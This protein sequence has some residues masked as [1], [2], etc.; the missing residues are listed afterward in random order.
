MR[1]H[2]V[3]LRKVGGVI[4]GEIQLHLFA[5]DFHLSLGKGSFE[6]IGGAFVVGAEGDG[7]VAVHFEAE[8]IVVLA[9]FG[10][11]LADGRLEGLVDGAFFCGADFGVYA[12][13][14]VVNVEREGG[15]L[16]QRTAIEENVVAEIG[17]G[18]DA[19]FDAIIGGA[20]I[21]AGLSGG[22]SGK[23]DNQGELRKHRQRQSF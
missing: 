22:W 17:S 2:G 7:V 23:S 16:L 13:I 19:D 14:G 11:F 21:V 18:A 6:A 8:F 20:Q 15:I 1:K 5:V 9:N 10:E 3:F 4:G 12:Q